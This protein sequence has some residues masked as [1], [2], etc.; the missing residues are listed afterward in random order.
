MPQPRL[1][2]GWRLYTLRQFHRQGV[3][4]T[5][6]LEKGVLELGRL[7]IARLDNDP[8]YPDHGVLRFTM[9][10]GK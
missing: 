2:M 8:D 10:G 4:A 1:W 9:E 6:P 7:E 5:T 3:P